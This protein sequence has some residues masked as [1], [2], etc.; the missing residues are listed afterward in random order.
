M[1]TLF[2][3]KKINI[4]VKMIDDFRPFPPMFHEHMEIVYVL[5]GNVRMQIEENSRLLTPG[6]IGLVFPYVVHSYERSADS[7]SMILMFSPSEIGYTD[8]RILQY[9]PENPYLESAAD[10]W[11]LLAKIYEYTNSGDRE[12][13]KV[14][15]LYLATLISELFLSVPVKKVTDTDL[16]VTQRLLSYCAEH[17]TENITIKSTATHLHMSESYISKIFCRKLDCNFRDYIN[18]LR[19]TQ[20]QNLLSSSSMRI[21]DIMLTCGFR[22]QSSFNRVF[23][24]ECGMSPREYR[25]KFR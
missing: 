10:F 9:K 21:I 8:K 5:K 16:T 25:E 19:I 22:N 17:Y 12:R 23:L 4:I 13:K 18:T 3:N 11:P 24:Q 15:E 1:R 6:Q 2:E 14:A 20:A 7:Q